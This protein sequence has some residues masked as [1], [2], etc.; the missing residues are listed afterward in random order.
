MV[1]VLAIRPI[2]ARSSSTGQFEASASEA[3]LKRW[4]LPD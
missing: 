3:R 2:T 1:C 4:L